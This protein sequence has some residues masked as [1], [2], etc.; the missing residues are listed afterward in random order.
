MT[1]ALTLVDLDVN[2]GVAHESV[3]VR[4]P[5]AE[6]KVAGRAVGDHVLGAG[7]G[8]KRHIARSAAGKK[9]T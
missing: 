6:H 2:A 3:S 1:L 4:D 7:G 8:S 5:A 9:N